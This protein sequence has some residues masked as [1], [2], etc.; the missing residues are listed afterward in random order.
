MLSNLFYFY[1]I[2]YCYIQL[3]LSSLIVFYSSPFLFFIFLFA[4]IF[5][6]D[7]ITTYF[8]IFH[9][10]LNYLLIVQQITISQFC[11]FSN[12][13]TAL[14]FIIILLPFSISF[15]IYFLLFKTYFSQNGQVEERTDSFYLHYDFPPYCTGENGTLRH[16][17]IH[18][19]TLN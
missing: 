3:Y 18:R 13:I 1:F 16:I 7:L 19:I 4:N 14:F 10:Y 9:A 15:D 8:F 6:I 2:K 17:N 5:V 11:V 12:F